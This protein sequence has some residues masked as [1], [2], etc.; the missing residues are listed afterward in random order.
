MINGVVLMKNGIKIKK[1]VERMNNDKN[2]VSWKSVQMIC[3]AI[4]IDD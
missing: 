1:L 2:C 3:T 4:S